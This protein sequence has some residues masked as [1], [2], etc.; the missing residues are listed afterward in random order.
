MNGASAFCEASPH[1]EDV[2][3]LYAA[4]SNRLEQIVRRRVRA[5]QAVIEDACQF[6]WIKLLQHSSRVGREAILPWLAVTAAHEALKLVRRGDREVSLDA[7]LERVDDGAT[8]SRE[9]GPDDLAEH[10]DRLRAISGL[11]LRQQQFLWLHAAGL[12]Y[13]EMAR[14]TGCTPRTVER[15]LLRAKQGIRAM[16]AGWRL[17]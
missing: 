7:A 9:P 5:P 16:D 15:Q 13:D 2:G 1:G 8:R 14:L 3:E 12:T 11:P 10:R 17:R 6:A 4:L